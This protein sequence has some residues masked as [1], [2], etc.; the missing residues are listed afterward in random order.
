MKK[1]VEHYLKL[2][3]DEKTAMYFAQGRKKITAVAAADNYKLILDFDNG[4]RRILD[5]TPMMQPGTVFEKISDERIFSGVYLDDEHCV[6]WDIDPDIDSNAV[7]NNK[8][9]LCPDTCYIDST[10]VA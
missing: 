8:I 6:S 9:D 2:G 4:E 3:F 7:W 10:P 5:M 1:S